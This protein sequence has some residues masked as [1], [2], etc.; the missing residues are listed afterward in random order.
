MVTFCY[1]DFT[2]IRLVAHP[3]YMAKF[4]L[5]MTPSI[6]LFY[7]PPSVTILYLTRWEVQTKNLTSYTL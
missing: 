1:F 5:T 2:H 6:H 7:H 4:T 3:V